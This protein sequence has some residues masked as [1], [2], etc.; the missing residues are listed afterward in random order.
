M[1]IMCTVAGCVVV[2]LPFLHRSR[3]LSM[4]RLHEYFAT[5]FWLVICLMPFQTFAPWGVQD[6]TATTSRWQHPGL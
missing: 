3:R 4:Y 6:T 5:E 1:A 2:L